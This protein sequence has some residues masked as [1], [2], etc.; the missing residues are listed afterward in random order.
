[1][2]KF[3]FLLA[4]VLASCSALPAGSLKEYEDEHAEE[5]ENMFQGD[6]IISQQEIDQFNG[7]IDE[8]RRWA[9]NI[10]PYT[11][12]M[13][14][15]SELQ[16]LS[17][18]R[19]NN[20]RKNKLSDS[21]Q[22]AYIHKAA[23]TINNL[24]CVTLVNRTNERDYIEVS[25]D[26]TGCSSYVGRQGG[27]QVISL[28]PNTPEVGCFRLYTIVHEF[29]HALGFHHMQSSHDRDQYVNIVWANIE[30]GRDNNFS[31]YGSSRVTHF[32]VPYDYGSVMHYPATAFSI[33][34]E[35]TIVPLQNLGGLVMGQRTQLSESDSLRLKRMYGCA[36]VP[37]NA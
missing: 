30:S 19:Q 2:L 34:G 21:E 33:N 5:L 29:L 11:I 1:M 4:V 6:M 8:S 18:I 27:R 22:A 13:A 25:G 36:L 35:A 24:H 15:F 26:S 7:L 10:V 17:Q 9:D 28:A 16:I 32:A 23:E 3:V 37:H 20:I 31:L 14:R 12:N